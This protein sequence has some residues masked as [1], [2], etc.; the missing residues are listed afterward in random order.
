LGV[1]AG[2]IAVGGN[3]RGSVLNTGD[4][5][6]L[7]VTSSTAAQAPSERTE[8]LKAL[9]EIRA[10]LQ[11][12]SGPRASTARREADA[13]VQAASADGSDKEAIGAALESA[14]EVARKTTEFAEIAGRLAPFL[15]TVTGWLGNEW[16]HLISLLG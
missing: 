13:A 9:G 8:V 12:L 11:G 16:S 3:V 4:G 15:H 6:A 7:T 14:L 2:G 1:G 5:N 10:A